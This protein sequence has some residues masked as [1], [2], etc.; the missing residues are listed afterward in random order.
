MVYVGS[1]IG[2][3]VLEW[4]GE[5]AGFGS[6]FLYLYQIY[7]IYQKRVRKEL[8]I[9]YR[10]M[11]FAYGAF[12]VATLLGIVWAFSRDETIMHAAVWAL[13]VFFIFLINGHLYKII[14]FLVWFHRFSDLVGKQKV[15]M[16]HEMYPKK[17]ADY[18]YWMSVAGAILIFLGLLFQN[19]A[20]FKSGGSFMLV[21]AIFLATSVK[22]M[23][24][25]DQKENG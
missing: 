9:W 25:F 20:L 13:F 3:Q 22:W 14:P 7:L 12:V 5:I 8:D 17:Q 15:P 1:I 21:G 23:A 11:L 4:L 18:Y 2:F 10:S 16:L 24:G 19:D 6:V